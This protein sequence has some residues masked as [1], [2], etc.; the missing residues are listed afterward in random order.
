MV[1][2]FDDPDL[3]LG[4]HIPEDD[5]AVAAAAGKGALVDGVPGHGAGLLLV[6][7]KGLHLLL[8][9]SEKC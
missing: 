3:L 9:V 1:Y 4:A 5:G 2:L 7:A 6:T 8:Q